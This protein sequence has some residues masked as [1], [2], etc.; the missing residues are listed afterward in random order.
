MPCVSSLIFPF[1]LSLLKQS[2]TVRV[3]LNAGWASAATP[4]NIILGV[5]QIG[6]MARI[7]G[8]QGFG[9]IGLFVAT[10]ALF[11]SFFKVTSAE[12]VMVYTSKATAAND[13]ELVRHILRYCY[14]IDLVTS[15]FSALLVITA[16]SI[17]TQI[18]HIG[19]EQSHLLALFALT[20]VFQSTLEDSR[21]VLYLNNHFSWT[22][23]QSV[24]HSA[25]KTA[26]MA[27]LFLIGAGLEE[28]VILLV[29]MSLLD[30][31]SMWIMSRVSLRIKHGNRLKYTE[32]AWW[33]IPREVFRFQVLG[34]LRRCTKSLNRYLDIL[35]IGYVGTSVQ[36]GLYRS[37]KQIADHA[38]T[39]ISGFLSSF[40]R[41]YTNLY[42]S[43]DME[44]LRLI[45][46][47][48]TLIFILISVILG[49]ILWF[50][51]EVIIQI[52]L[53]S[54]FLPATNIVRVLMIS[55]VIVSGMFPLYSLPAAVGRAE[56]AF[57]STL[58]GL[59]AQITALF[60]LVPSVGA[61]GAAWANVVYTV[62]W[63]LVLLPSV[64]KVLVAD[65]SEMELK[66]PNL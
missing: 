52:I 15:V 18:F 6:F 22:F 11:N 47:R 42:F 43:K 5:I 62:I 33:H 60:I 50:G 53:G 1:S 35:F 49:G 61:I 12:T 3:I 57:W 56:P 19:S 17:L 23:Y 14:R 58:I 54:E 26:S 20:M 51:A 39:P 41:E 46:R 16:S 29:L 36:V 21:S 13:M 31:F 25:I 32:S 48:F 10:C 55:V 28:V 8:P 44:G 66:K 9:I 40:F 63:A 59:V 2:L 7:L 24:G 4:I 34:H 30:G 45:A 37:A 38:Y 65:E 64:L 27:I